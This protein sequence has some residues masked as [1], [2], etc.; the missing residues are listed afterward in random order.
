[1]TRWEYRQESVLVASL[2]AACSRA[3]AEGWELACDPMQAMILPPP[4]HTMNA[5]RLAVVNTG[6]EA[7]PGFVLLFKRPAGTVG[8]RKNGRAVDNRIVTP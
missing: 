5:G 4:V 1:M 7:A 2:V 3:G 6:E 8:D